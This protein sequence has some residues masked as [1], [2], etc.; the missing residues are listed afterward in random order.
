MFIEAV[1]QFFFLRLDHIQPA[2]KNNTQVLIVKNKILWKFVR[3]HY[4][5]CKVFISF[6]VVRTE[7][8]N[9]IDENIFFSEA[10]PQRFSSIKLSCNFTGITLCRTPFLKN[11]PE[12]LLLFFTSLLT[13][14]K[15]PFQFL[16]L[17]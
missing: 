8:L 5:I 3:S 7:V 17:G 1:K 14:T 6:I 4:G 13:S 2:F 11:T 10:V 15:N 16:K 12:G 9:L